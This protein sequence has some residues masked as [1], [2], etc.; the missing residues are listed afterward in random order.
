LKGA[1][2]V[3]VSSYRSFILN[4]FDNRSLETTT[5]SA[6]L[7][8][9]AIFFYG[10]ATPPSQGGD[11]NPRTWELEASRCRPVSVQTPVTAYNLAYFFAAAELIN[12]RFAYL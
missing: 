7:R 9:G 11:Y 2:G 5:P 4:G 12:F 3:V 1:D 10:A 6:P 8:Y